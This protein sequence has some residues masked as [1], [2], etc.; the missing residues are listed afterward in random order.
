MKKKYIFIGVISIVV[1]ALVL[2]VV[3]SDSKDVD[4]KYKVIEAEDAPDIDNDDYTNEGVVGENIVVDKEG[5]RVNSISSLTMQQE[6]DGFIITDLYLSSSVKTPDY[7]VINFNIKNDSNIMKNFN[8]AFN[9]YDKEG[10]VIV[11]EIISFSEMEVGEEKNVSYRTFNP[12]INAY[13]YSF[14]YIEL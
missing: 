6:H 3:F 8:L 11:T 1:I 4:S 5:N 7:C 9:F 13:S 12:I 2:I 14:S 10:K